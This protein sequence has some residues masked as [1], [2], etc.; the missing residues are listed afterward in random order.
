MKEIFLLTCIV[1]WIIKKRREEPFKRPRMTRKL[2][3]PT[4][5]QHDLPGRRYPCLSLLR[6]YRFICCTVLST[7]PGYGSCCTHARGEPPRRWGR[8]SCAAER[9]S[10]TEKSPGV[11]LRK[12]PAKPRAETT[13]GEAGSEQDTEGTRPLI[14]LP[15]A[16]AGRQPQSPFLH[17]PITRKMY[18]FELL[19]MGIKI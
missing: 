17:Q 10:T 8:G 12:S 6:R 2:I 4:P 18:W 3:Y 1:N 5:E 7:T 15:A 11:T 9:W 13:P 19:L 16:V 14:P